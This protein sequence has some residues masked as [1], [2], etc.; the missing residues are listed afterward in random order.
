MLLTQLFDISMANDVASTYVTVGSHE[1]VLEG[2][3]TALRND[4]RHVAV[5]SSKGCAFEVV[6]G[7]A[8][9]AVRSQFSQKKQGSLSLRVTSN[10]KPEIAYA[11]IVPLLGALWGKIRGDDD[12]F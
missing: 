4:V 1:S 2:L 3:V 11:M 7:V 10:D 9:V 8:Q 5:S 6:C 12:S